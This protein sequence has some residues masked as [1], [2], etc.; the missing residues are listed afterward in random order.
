MRLR[1][2][3]AHEGSD[4]GDMVLLALALQSR[5]L[6]RIKCRDDAVETRRRERGCQVNGLS[7]IDMA[8]PQCAMPHAGSV[9][10]IA[11]KAAIAWGQ[12]KE[13]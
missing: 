2:V 5:G 11:V 13:W 12:A 7:R 4:G 1:G 6:R 8:R 10:S 3:P 9:R